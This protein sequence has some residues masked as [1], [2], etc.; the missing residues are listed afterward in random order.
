MYAALMDATSPTQRLLPGHEPMLLL[1]PAH[2]EITAS[3]TT[4]VSPATEMLDYFIEKAC[5]LASGQVPFTATIE[6]FAPED[7]TW[8][9]SLEEEYGTP[10]PIHYEDTMTQSE[11]LLWIHR[12]GET[13]VLSVKELRELAITLHLPLPKG[14]KRK[15]SFWLELIG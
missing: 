10:E 5:C 3:V 4:T 15:K 8:E 11:T 9:E 7:L 12:Q 1:S 14:D 2:E 6:E 13:K